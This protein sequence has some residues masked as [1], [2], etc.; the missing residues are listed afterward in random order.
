M[1]LL[2]WVHGIVRLYL[3]YERRLLPTWR[4]DKKTYQYA[5]L[6]LDDVQTA[7]TVK[8]PM[9]NRYCQYNEVTLR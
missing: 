1:L 7:A 9:R 3:P 6:E 5:I 2:G 8:D 4:A